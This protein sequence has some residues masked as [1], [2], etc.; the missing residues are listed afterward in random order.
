MDLEVITK[1]PILSALVAGC[2]A[3]GLTALGASG[4]FL[5]RTVTQKLLDAMLGFAAGVMIAASFWSLLAPSIE[6]SE[7]LGITKWL[8]PAIGFLV[9]GAFLWIVDKILPHLNVGQSRSHPEGLPTEWHTTVL[10]F[11]AIT[12][13]NFPEGLA[14]GVAFGAAAAGIPGASIAGAIALAIGIGIQNF[15]E[16]FAVSMPFR[17]VGVGKLKSF[18][19]GQ[20]SAIIEPIAAVIGAV[21][22]LAMRPLL[23]YAL[24]FAAGA[25]I[26]VSVEEII[27]ES[28]KNSTDVATIGAMLG[29]T[30]MMILD[31][32][33]G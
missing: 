31:V 26:Y 14:V 11:L 24:A 28:Q 5:F 27:P 20:G 8:P 3:W 21:G 9:G 32:A 7:Q 18:L 17:R 2:F 15:P 29:F 13:H 4:V 12:F 25:M 19:F 10:L 22:V 30:I 6:L 16:G 33:L 23:P 1:H